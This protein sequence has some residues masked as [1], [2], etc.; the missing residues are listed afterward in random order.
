MKLNWKTFLR[1]ESTAIAGLSVYSYFE[2]INGN[3]TLFALLI[4]AP[5]LSMAGYLRDG[6]TGAMLYNLFHNYLI[7]GII[8]GYGIYNGN[9]LAQKVGFIW[10][11]HIAGDRILGYGLK[12]KKG[13][14]HTHLS[15]I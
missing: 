11:A 8:L 12:K 9:I 5:D 7:P 6:N 14:K 10:T 4:L 3:V 15:K 13:F 1:L 2:L